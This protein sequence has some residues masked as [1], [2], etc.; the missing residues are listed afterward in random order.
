MEDNCKG[1]RSYTEYVNGLGVYVLKAYPCCRWSDD[2][3][4]GEC[5]CASC[6]VKTMC[7][8]P[9]KPYEKWEEDHL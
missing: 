8:N 7:G 1:C 5:P 9:C 2:N 6:I 4:N 3:T